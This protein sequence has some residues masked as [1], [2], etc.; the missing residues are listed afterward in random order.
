MGTWDVSITLFSAGVPVM[1]SGTWEWTSPQ[2]ARQS[3]RIVGTRL[4]DGQIGLQ[5]VPV[6]SA[7]CPSP[8]PSLV[9]A[10]G[11]VVSV[12]LIEPDRLSGVVDAYECDGVLRRQIELTRTRPPG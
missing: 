7:G 1:L 9:P 5:L 11:F 10:G 8:P 2:E 6:T 3:G 12:V 4:P